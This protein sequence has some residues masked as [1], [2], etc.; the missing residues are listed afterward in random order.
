MTNAGLAL[1]AQALQGGFTVP[2][3]RMIFA[4]IPGLDPDSEPS[5]EMDYPPEENIVHNAEI[6]NTGKLDENR[7]IYSCVLPASLGPFYINWIGLYSSQ[8]QTLIAVY[9]VPRHYKS[10]TTGFRVGNTMYKNFAIQ[11]ENIGNLS[12]ITVPPESWQYNLD[13]RYASVE[14][15][16]DGRY[17]PNAHSHEIDQVNGL[18]DALDGKAPSLHSH[19]IGQVNGLQDALNGKAPS[20]HSHEIIQVNGLQD[21]LNGKADLNQINMAISSHNSDGNAH[22]GILMKLNGDNY[23]VGNLVLQGGD[24]ASKGTLFCLKVQANDSVDTK[25]LFSSN[26][27][28]ET[29]VTDGSGD[30]YYRWYNGSAATDIRMASDGSLF[31]WNE[32]SQKNVP[33][34]ARSLELGGETLDEVCF[35]MTANEIAWS[36]LFLNSESHLCVRTPNSPSINGI[37]HAAE[38]VIEGIGA[39]GATLD[40]IKASRTAY[41]NYSAGI[42][43]KAV[44][45]E[46]DYTVPQDGW[47]YVHVR[48]N[49]KLYINGGLCGQGYDGDDCV[50][51]PVKAGD[52]VTKLNTLSAIF[53]PNR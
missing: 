5:P 41:P 52:I 33:F 31:T 51:L 18:R 10:N 17:A 21:A 7:V 46:A 48:M 4:D 13:D 27:A 9:H 8:Y 43:I 15:N 6:S 1:F 37:V 47:L 3:D 38:F 20:L 40:A 32:F 2:V 42:D 19:E 45:K 36:E 44:V 22:D 28:I 30:P 39:V 53:Y 29:R 35:R 11:Y 23:A 16:H 34:K 25:F 26:G 24:D 50:F 49:A 14:H 12:G